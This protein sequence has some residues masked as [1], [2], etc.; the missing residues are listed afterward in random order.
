MGTFNYPIFSNTRISQHFGA[1]PSYYKRFGLRGHSGVDFAVR[2]GTAVRSSYW[3][4]VIKVGN[5]PKGYG[6]Y[7]KVEYENFV[8]LYG[9]LSS[10]ITKKGCYVT[11]GQI[12]GYSGN[13]G[14]STGP[15]LHFGIQDKTKLKNGYKG[16]VDPMQFLK[17]KENSARVKI[18]KIKKEVAQIRKDGW[19][20]ESMY[21]HVTYI[22]RILKQK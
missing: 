10:I 14:L 19:T 13:T 22:D 6:L 21:I 7:I 17:T 16:Y 5:N 11:R 8:F 3:G 1:R 18:E 12:I 15:H 9:H 4:T 20:K 2:V